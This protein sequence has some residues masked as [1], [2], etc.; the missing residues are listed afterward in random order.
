M[1]TAVWAAVLDDLEAYVADLEAVA[2]DPRELDRFGDHGVPAYEPPAELGPV[3]AHLAERATAVSS[4]M[5]GVEA[6]LTLALE[7][8]REELSA[9]QRFTAPEGHSTSAAS[10]YLDTTA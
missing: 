1:S 3:P 7:S 9:T 5:L 10:Y 2:A 4:R 8:V 6:S